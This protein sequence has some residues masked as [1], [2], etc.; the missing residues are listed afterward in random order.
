MDPKDY[1]SPI[2]AGQADQVNISPSH[3]SSVQK[4][5]P[6]PPIWLVVPCQRFVNEDYDPNWDGIVI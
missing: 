5:H 1:G 2:L 4:P 3:M 6:Q